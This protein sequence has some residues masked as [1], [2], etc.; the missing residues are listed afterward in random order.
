MH[1]GAPSTIIGSS[2][3]VEREEM[4]EERSKQHFVLVHGIGHGAWCWYKL[5]ALLRSAGHTVTALDLAGS[6][7]HPQRLDEVRSFGDY[8]RPLMEVMASIPPREKVVLV[9]HSYGGACVA[10]AM[11]R[12]PEKVLVAVFVA[13]IMP[14]PACSLARIAEEFFKGH[15]LEA[16]MD[17]TLVVRKDPLSICSIS[18]GYNY[19]STRL[20]QLSPPEDLTLATM[21]VRPASCFLDDANEMMQLTEERFGSVRRVFIVCKEDKSTSEAFQLWMIQR[22][23]GAEVMEIEAADHMVMLSRPRELFRLLVEIAVEHGSRT[24]SH[25]LPRPRGGGRLR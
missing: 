20:Y 15:P 18:F 4:E 1:T 9:G 13:G 6:G 19:L 21:L 22:S 24:S 12:F 3:S 2:L 14:S 7:V 16:Y 5:T 17:S 10:L 8:A 25:D 23:P 11:E